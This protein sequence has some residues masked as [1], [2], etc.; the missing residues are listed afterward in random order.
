MSVLSDAIKRLLESPEPHKQSDF[1]P[2]QRKALEAFA[3]STRLLEI[4]KS[5]RTTF[6]RVLNPQGLL[7]Y[8]QQLHPLSETD[9]PM[10]LPARS[11]NVGINRNSKKGKSSH[12]SFYLLMKAWADGVIWQDEQNV[13][14]VTFTTEQFGAAVLQ[15]NKGQE[16]RCNRALLFVENQALFDQCDWVEADFDGCLIYY[17]GQIPD[18]LLVWIA[19]RKRSQEIILFP[20]Y[21]GVGLSNYARLADAV[22]PDTKLSF[23]W[24]PNWKSKLVQYGD[25]DIWLKTRIQF[26]NAFEKLNNLGVIDENLIELARL[27]QL[28]GKALEQESIW[29]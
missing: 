18:L 4:V 12:E 14:Q 7:G 10:D 1:S 13:L 27:S 15:V 23:Y 22:H 19:E 17:A 25:A 2:L 16:W 21:D 24:L 9:L 20:D 28:N 11:R 6:Y 3:S 8:F 26:E 29:L 5:G